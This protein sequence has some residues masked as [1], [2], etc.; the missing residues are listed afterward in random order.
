MANFPQKVSTPV[1]LTHSSKFDLTFTHD[2]TTNF[3]DFNV[4]YACELVPKQEVDV[5]HNVF[6]RMT[7]LLVPTYGDAEIHNRA[8][9]VP[10]R[11]IFPAWNDFITDSVHTYS[12][13][14]S[15]LVENVPMISNKLFSNL[16]VRYLAAPVGLYTDGMACDFVVYGDGSPLVYT[17]FNLT[18]KGARFMKLINSLG[19]RIDFNA[20]NVEDYFS[21]LP[22]LAVCKVY[23][24]WYYPSAYVQDEI[25]TVIN[26]WLKYDMGRDGAR[27]E[28]VFTVDDLLAI[29]NFLDKVCYDSDYFVSAW[30]NPNVPNDGAYSDYMIP[31]VED[32]GTVEVHDSLYGTGPHLISGTGGKIS[33]YALTALKSL[34]DYMRRHQISGSRTLDRYLSRF[35][36]TL[37]S[38]KLQRSV[39]ISDYHNNQPIQFGDVTSTSDTTDIGG[40]PLGAYAGKGISANDGNSFKFRTDEYG[41]LIIVSTVVPRS[42]NVQGINRQVKHL[43]RLDYFTPEFDNLGY[44]AIGTKELF[45][46]FNSKDQL[47]TGASNPTQGIDYGQL[48][49]GFTPRYAEY[50]VARDIVTGDYNLGSKNVDLAPWLMNRDVTAMVKKVGVDKL[51]HSRNF[52]IGTD[53]NQ[54]NRIF[55]GVIDESVDNF[56]VHHIFKIDTTFPGKKLFDNYEFTDEDKAETVAIDINGVK[57]N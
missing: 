47:K 16:F 7:P 13:N 30:D 55:N 39:F 40:A 23:Y 53:S 33:Q 24:D 35:G 11:T 49:F 2:T 45:V 8:F 3:M 50:K 15:S 17:G 29:C 25:A 18:T 42:T 20:L 22:L 54:Y 52:L 44:Q 56:F 48:V 46:P 12:D 32:A 27:F 31:N 1:A 36:F 37:S 4:A 10:F 9:F 21:A 26:K 43:T 51:Y 14:I 6:A 38:E 41:M 57:A 5:Y 34:T 19:Y 28:D